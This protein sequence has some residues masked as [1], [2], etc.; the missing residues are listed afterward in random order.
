MI[1]GTGLD[2]RTGVSDGLAFSCFPHVKRPS[3]GTLAIVREYEND[4]GY[5]SPHT[6]SL[7][8]W[9]KNGVLLL[10]TALS[11]EKQQT[12]AHSKIGWE[13]LI[14]E[15]VSRLSKQKSRMVFILW[16]NQARE[17]RA[18]IDETKHLVIVADAPGRK[19]TKKG[20]LFRGHKPF[21]RANEFL[22]KNKI[23]W[24]LQ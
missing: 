16:G 10:N 3:A 6:Y 23:D 14:I 4:L 15:V 1:L 13:K 21:S 5:R 9:A 24:R 12:R 8:S 7:R 11:G 19:P 18:L 17:Y 2:T 22:G 20:P